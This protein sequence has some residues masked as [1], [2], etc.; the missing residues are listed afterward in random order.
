MF[1]AKFLHDTEAV[2]I[3]IR[4]S[5][6]KNCGGIIRLLVVGVEGG[7]GGRCWSPEVPIAGVGGG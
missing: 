6:F 3:T 7:D 2:W 4:S 1:A 5:A